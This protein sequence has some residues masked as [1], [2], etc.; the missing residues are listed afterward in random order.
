MSEIQ[1][2]SADTQ[3]LRVMKK[4][5]F[6]QR[7]ICLLL[8]GVILAGVVLIRRITPRVQEISQELEALAGQAQTALTEL[9]GVSKSLGEIDLQGLLDNTNQMVRQGE[10]SFVEM[11]GSVSRAVKNLEDL[12]V[13]SFNQAIGR[14]NAVAG[15]LSSL[16]GK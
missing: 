13:E 12:D 14:L 15:T 6:W 1:S 3:L 11:S 7:L 9:E 16:F 10:E 4:Q 5:L 8:A 2:N